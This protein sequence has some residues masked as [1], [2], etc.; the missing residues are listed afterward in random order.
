MERTLPSLMA[1]GTLS[2]IIVMFGLLDALL[3]GRRH[4]LGWRRCY[5]CGYDLRATRDRCPECGAIPEKEPA[6]PNDFE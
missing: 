5:Q 4:R 6:P 3:G 1:V 2:A